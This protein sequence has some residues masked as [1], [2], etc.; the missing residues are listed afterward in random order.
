[1]L[2][3]RLLR[4]KTLQILY[5]Y[6]KSAYKTIFDAERELFHS[7]EKSYELYLLLLEMLP[8]I[9]HQAF[10]RADLM[11][12][13]ISLEKS[14]ALQ[15]KPLANNAICKFLEENKLFQAKLQKHSLN[16]QDNMKL[17]RDFMAQTIESDI[18]KEYIKEPQTFAGDKKIALFIITDLLPA[19]ESLDFYLEDKS[20]Y[21]NDDIEFLLEM[22]VKSIKTI[23]E[24]L[25]G[26][27][28]LHS[29][30]NAEEDRYFMLHL[31]RKTVEDYDRYTDIIEKNLAHWKLDRVAEIDLLL[32]KM[33]IVEAVQFPSIPVKV[34]L[35]EYIEIAKFY[36]TEKSGMF[37]NGMIDKICKQLVE[38]K[39]IV[40]EGR[41]LND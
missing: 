41:G 30:F 18:Y 29:Q 13:R 4:I 23:D 39:I 31:Y 1:M 24:N 14:E 12:Q 7:V 16:W 40:K 17:V 11:E 36:S 10:L 35:N 28:D 27:F 22:V 20:I 25:P 8:E 15:Y 9:S 21:W 3:R 32:I 34:T 26:K 5:A 19:S 38:E 37:I 6:Y 2:N 33:A